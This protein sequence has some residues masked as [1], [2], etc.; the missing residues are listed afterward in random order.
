MSAAMVLTVQPL[1]APA[2]ASFGD[3]IARPATGGRSINGGTSERYDDVT[4][5][6]LMADGG[7]PQM[8]FFESRPRKFPFICEALERHPLSTQAF[9]PVG[10]SPMLVLVANGDHEPDARACKAFITDG[11]QGV[12]FHR[13]VWH[14]PLVGLAGDAT[15]VVVGRAGSPNF[16]LRSFADG[17]RVR[18]IA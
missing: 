4:R 7:R 9:M 3:V 1:S 18:V 5:L 2:F 8:S 15:F 16:E 14:H 17:A 6:D 13:N 12:N 10:N 11:R